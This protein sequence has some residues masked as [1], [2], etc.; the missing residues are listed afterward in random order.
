MSP[1]PSH[2]TP[3]LPLSH[4][5]SRS[6]SLSLSFSASFFSSSLSL[7]L[8]LLL[9]ST[10]RE[11]LSLLSP[12][13]SVLVGGSSSSLLFRKKAYYLSNLYW[14]VIFSLLEVFFSLFLFSCLFVYAFLLCTTK[15]VYRSRSL[16]SCPLPFLFSCGSCKSFKARL[17]STSDTN[18]YLFTHN[19]SLSIPHTRIHTFSHTFSFPHIFIHRQTHT[20]RCFYSFFLSLSFS[21]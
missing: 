19:L 11:R 2:P 16:S 4:S 12:L 15:S 13:F 17:S 3:R 18:T 9:H 8:S 10:P 5:Q 1:D 14:M 7:S 20:E 6:L 21:C